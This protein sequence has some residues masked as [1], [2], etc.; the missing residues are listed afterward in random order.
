[1]G[2]HKHGSNNGSNRHNKQSQHAHVHQ[3]PHQ[4]SDENTAWNKIKTGL[5]LERRE[6][7]KPIAYISAGTGSVKA[8]TPAQQST[9]DGR[10]KHTNSNK[11]TFSSSSSHSSVT[12][13]SS[14]SAHISKSPSNTTS[15]ASAGSASNGG[16][17]DSGGVGKSPRALFDSSHV[18]SNIRW[19]R[20]GRPAPGFFN[21]GNTCYLNS[22][23]QCL[24]HLPPLAQCLSNDDIAQKALA[25]M[26]SSSQNGQTPIAVLFKGLVTDV[27]KRSNGKAFLPRSMV[28]SIRRVGKQF[29]PLRQEDAHEYLRHL[30]DCMHEEMLKAHKVKLADGKIAETTFISRVFG[31]NL[32]SELRCPK[33]PYVSRTFN[34]F[35]DL[36][37]DVTSGISSVESSLKLFSKTEQLT[38][39]N[40]WKCDGCKR[41]VLAKKQMTFVE[42]PVCLVLHLKRFTYGQGKVNKP[43]AFDLEMSVQCKHESVPYRLTAIVVHH[44]GSVHSGH[45]VAYVLAPNGVWN[46]MNDS[47][48]TPV[49]VQKVLSQQA[50]ICF[51]TREILS[52]QPENAAVIAT[53]SSPAAPAK[54]TSNA[55]TATASLSSESSGKLGERGAAASDDAESSEVDG[56][57]H[58]SLAK[59]PVKKVQPKVAADDASDS[60]SSSSG[61]SSSAS[62]DSDS[63]SE[64][65][66]IPATS[67]STIMGF[68]IRPG[69]GSDSGQMNLSKPAFP[70]PTLPT[71]L[72]VPIEPSKA[73]KEAILATHEWAKGLLE[74]GSD[75][76][77]D[78]EDEDGEEEEEEEED[79]AER[80]KET[81]IFLKPRQH[82]SYIPMKFDLMNRNSI[83]HLRSKWATRHLNRAP[84]VSL[85][86]LLQ[87]GWQLQGARTAVQSSVEEDEEDDEGEEDQVASAKRSANSP[88][89]ED[90]ED[91]EESDDS[92]VG[93]SQMQSP[94]AIFTPQFQ[95][96]GSYARDS[97]DV[98]YDIAVNPLNKSSSGK[99]FKSIL[100]QHSMRAKEVSSEGQW[101]DA[102][103]PEDV[104][105]SIERNK[106]NQRSKE[107]ALLASRQTSEW[108]K[109]LD[110]GRVK[111]LQKDKKSNLLE[112]GSLGDGWGSSNGSGS[113]GASKSASANGTATKIQNK[114]QKVLDSRATGTGNSAAASPGASGSSNSSSNKHKKRHNDRDKVYERDT[115]N[116]N[117]NNNESK[118]KRKKVA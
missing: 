97:S 6:A 60:S 30:V 104:L 50:Y 47:T 105:Q 77:S 43:V 25:N 22:V 78:S 26:G 10:Q 54:P 16:K 95:S 103:I 106:Q 18:A 87:R 94:S 39:G 12:P 109:Q 32:C 36:S 5:Q 8:H 20:I 71:D 53:C 113:K 23:L 40:E 49:T 80:E 64:D 66:G 19:G 116:V 83:Q 14:S 31:G 29:R 79:E 45:Y 117:I 114:F 86:A 93:K 88:D 111:K 75:S 59:L 58:S 96:H 63:D 51:Y 24:V 69:S 99:T 11:T 112:K 34:Y 74:E 33:C 84:P 55:K 82:R 37:L 38:V 100:I 3:K 118:F 17:V 115:D 76:D 44:G 46:E 108:D 70:V 89:D 68:P 4:Q 35:Q 62:S 41:R 72:C 90:E 91:E 101:D 73:S 2:K 110:S 42:L 7:M 27:W 92:E 9:S 81:Q 61:Y 48:V 57:S 67:I 1:M 21:H 85:K 102:D 28:M 107:Q 52:A 13:A 98:N 56:T 15:Y 65:A